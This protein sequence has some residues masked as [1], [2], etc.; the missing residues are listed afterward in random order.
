MEF[1]NFSSRALVEGAYEPRTSMLTLWFTS[2]PQEGYD[3]PGVPMYIWEGL[4]AA[5][6]S[7][8]YYN[9][10]IRDTYGHRRISSGLRRR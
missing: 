1:Q 2:A 3:Y 7:G 4:C 9:L 8:T 6:S 5:G 10:H